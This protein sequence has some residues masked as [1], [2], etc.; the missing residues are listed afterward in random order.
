MDMEEE[1][2]ASP[3]MKPSELK[4]TYGAT[5]G[6]QRWKI[7]NARE[8]T[9]TCMNEVTSRVAAELQ[10]TSAGEPSHLTR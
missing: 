5:Q 3:S 1:R 9:R 8:S 4:E 10:G 7:E 6:E 2:K